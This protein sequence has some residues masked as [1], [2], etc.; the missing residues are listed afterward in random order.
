MELP[1]RASSTGALGACKHPSVSVL[2]M[3]RSFG[4]RFLDKFAERPYLSAS[5]SAGTI[6]FCGDVIAQSAEFSYQR[7]KRNEPFNNWSIQSAL[8]SW[9]KRRTLA[10]WSF[11][12]FYY[13]FPVKFF[14]ILYDKYLT[15]FVIKA[16]T[17]CCLHAPFV[18]LP[19][20]YALT[21]TVKGQTMEGPHGWLQQLQDEWFVAATASAAFWLPMQVFCFGWVPLEFRIQFVCILNIM[22][23]STLS[24]YSNRKRR[25]GLDSTLPAS[26]PMASSDGLVVDLTSCGLAAGYD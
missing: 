25:E 19:S 22:H 5:L 15:S 26:V 4:R 14:Y 3:A 18:L 6:I 11:G 7:Q 24:W 23:K 8:A 9:D 10:M 21:G 2:S 16:F 1:S 20:F 17:D 13:G 12:T